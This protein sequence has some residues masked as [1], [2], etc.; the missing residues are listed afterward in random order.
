MSQ[1]YGWSR[2]YASAAC[3]GMREVG[4]LQALRLTLGAKLPEPCHVDTGEKSRHFNKHMGEYEN[5]IC[6]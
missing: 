1:E 4:Q 2:P 5:K 3:V 6:D